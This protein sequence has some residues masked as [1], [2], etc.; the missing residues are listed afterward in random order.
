M[1]L[2]KTATRFPRLLG[3][4][5]VAGLRLA[6]FQRVKPKQF[7]VSLDQAMGLV[8]VGVAL[9]LVADLV[10]LGLSADFNIYAL[11]S[12]AFSLVLAITAGYVISKVQKKPSVVLTLFVVMLSATPV[13]SVLVMVWG[14]VDQAA[15]GMLWVPG[16]KLISVSYYLILAWYLAVVFRAVSL[17]VSAHLVRI[18]GLAM[19]YAGITLLPLFLVPDQD[20][21]QPHYDDNFNYPKVNAEDVFYAQDA[22]LDTAL[23]DLLPSRRG[24]SDLYFVGFGSYFAQD[25]FMREIR[26]IRKLFDERFDTRDRSVA[27]I[28]N[29]ITVIDTPIASRTNLSRTLHHLGSIMNPE[30]DVLFLYLTSHGSSNHR[31]SVDFWP[32]PL[33]EMSPEQLKQVLDESGIKWRVIVISAC[34]SGGFIERLKDDHTVVMAS[35]SADKQS[36]GCGSGYEYT[37]FGQALFDQELRAGY[38]F[39][40]AFNGAAKIIAK[41][42]KKEGLDASVPQMHAAPALVQKLGAME[43]RLARRAHTSLVAPRSASVQAMQ[44]LTQ[45]Q[46]KGRP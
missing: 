39:V 32:L 37:Y 3:A 46:Q 44:H 12:V 36:F 24:V 45:T 19:V 25:V 41:R 20:F 10:P 17:L 22:L 8:L 16:R 26:S 15:A 7:S 42:E 38:S 6:F 27:L 5:L 11:P 31:L 4:N 34:Y 18:T 2:K 33:N 29:A 14:Y 1:A 21:W 30:E 43:K 9:D 35:A 23:Q 13:F 40:Q 28:N